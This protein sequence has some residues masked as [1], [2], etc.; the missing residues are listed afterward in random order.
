MN[1]LLQ[2]TESPIWEFP[3]I[4]ERDTSIVKYDYVK[5]YEDS[6]GSGTLENADHYSFTTNN[7]DLWLLPSESYLNLTIRLRNEDGN[8]YVWQNRAAVGGNAA[9]VAEDVSLSDNGFNIFEEARYYVDD[10]EVERIDNVG[11]ATL[12]NNVIKYTSDDKLKTVK[13]SQLW[14]LNEDDARRTYVRNCSGT[15]H[16]LLP[17]NKIFTFCEQ[18]D[19]VFRGVKHRITFTLN[20]PE[21]LIQKANAVADGQVA[22]TKCLWMVPYTEP[23]LG[24]MARLETQL[25]KDSSFNL[26]WTALNVY[27]NQPARNTDVRI[28]LSSTIHKPQK[29]FVALQ[30]LNRTTSQNHSSM[31]FDNM[32][33]EFCNVEINSVQFPDKE[34]KNNFTTREVME[35][36]DRFLQASGYKSTIDFET[37]RTS[38][39][40]FHIDVSH[41]KPELYE[42]TQFPN[43]VVNLKFR[44][45]PAHDYLVWVIIYNQRDATLNLENKKMRV[46]R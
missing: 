12:V 41:H 42:N 16:M 39:P 32:N 18:V 46:I 1:T 11:I 20:K 37:F 4:A 23:S 19:H 13:H 17:L 5:V 29:I 14:F 38:Y 43:I 2:E 24:T 28:A 15:I 40:I 27:R 30:N 7:E 34:L 45:V 26:T 6:H 10:K 9:A 25:A 8:Q 31:L 3:S 33:I 44:A 36:Y 22:I 21:R 35:L